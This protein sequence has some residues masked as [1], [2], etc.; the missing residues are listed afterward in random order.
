M[1]PAKPIAGLSF[2][3]DDKWSYL[4]THGEAGWES[5]PSFLPVLIPRA[6]EFL[7]AHR[8]TATF[9]VVGQDAALE[10]NRALLASVAAAG[11]E[12][13]NHSFHHEPWLHLYSEKEIAAELD[14]AEEHIERATGQRPVGFRGP[15]FSLSGALLAELARR[16]YLYDASTLPNILGPL[17]RAYYFRTAAFDA[18]E[19]RRRGRFNGTLGDGLRPLKPY[20]WRVGA[21]GLIELPVTTMPLFRLPIHASYLVALY[22]VSPALARRYFTAA[23]RLCRW[24]GTTPSIMLHPTDLLGA[25]DAGELSFFPGM[26]LKSGRKRAMMD[27]LIRLLASRFTVVT[28]AEHARVAA[29]GKNLPGVEPGFR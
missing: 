11:H 23:L 9:F 14:L 20:R 13:G 16:G 28:L 24:T 22:A 4:K 6:L 15:G 5:L 29:G 26:G 12:I 7:A 25:D 27:D 10:R 8:L 21:R 2:D 19:R 3:L 1:K 18:R 17:G